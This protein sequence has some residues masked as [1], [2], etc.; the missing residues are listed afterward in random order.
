MYG[1]N[2]YGERNAYKGTNLYGEWAGKEETPGGSSQTG[3]SENPVTEDQPGDPTMAAG[4][5]GS[6]TP[7]AGSD[8]IFPAGTAGSLPPG[9]SV[10]PMYSG[11]GPAAGQPAGSPYPAGMGVPVRVIPERRGK[12]GE[13][14]EPI[15]IF[16]NR[17]SGM[18]TC[19]CHLYLSG[20]SRD[21]STGF[22]CADDGRA[23]A[24]LQGSG[25]AA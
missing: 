2:M 16:R 23:G 22:V 25:G 5:S 18:G 13:H 11:A 3:I 6:Q 1:E 24:V 21:L 14:V 8:G 20:I 4:A 7:G 12:T 19:V 10:G 9:G 17:M 15:C